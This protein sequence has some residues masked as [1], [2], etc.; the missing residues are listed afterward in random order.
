MKGFLFIGV[1]VASLLRYALPFLV[2][3]VL[4]LVALFLLRTE[5]HHRRS[6]LLVSLGAMAFCLIDALLLYALPRLRL[7]F[8][9]PGFTLS[10]LIFLRV[11]IFLA[12]VFVFA[13]VA[14]QTGAPVS[15]LL[16]W[17]VNALLTLLAVYAFTIEPFSLQVS[18]LEI[19]VPQGQIQQPLRIVQLSDLHIER[20]TRREEEILRRVRDLQPDVIVLTGDYVN[21]SYLA[22][23][24]AIADTRDFLA[25]L[26]APR[27]VFAVNGSV[28]NQQQMQRLFSG[29]KITI[30]N[31]QVLPLTLPGGQITL[32]GVTDQERLRDADALY[33][34][35]AGIPTGS[36]T[37]LLYHTPD[38]AYEAS[39][40]VMDLYL[41]GHTHG[42]QIRLP[43]YGAIVTASAFGKQFEA[44][45]YQVGATT[46]YVSRGLGLEGS[47]APRAR[48]L[49]P[50]EIVVVDLIPT[51]HP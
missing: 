4:I 6:F 47:F 44:G 12:W 28:D 1:R 29:T 50:P 20:T 18:R 24:Q 36:F 17:L 9:P 5:A 45:R 30:L 43:L 51:T 21:L 48:F 46:L 42:G 10:V 11:G 8:G 25:Q 23:P 13:R 32:V 34:L 16:F 15:S 39:K 27:G 38:L 37:L 7:S 40:A 3:A 49:A 2:G 35:A 14:P 33:R 31:D 41:C 19:P 22:D 26:A